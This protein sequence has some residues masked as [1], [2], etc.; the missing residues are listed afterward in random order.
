[1]TFDEPYNNLVSIDRTFDSIKKMKALA[2]DRVQLY[3]DPETGE[4]L[5]IHDDDFIQTLKFQNPS[6]PFL[7]NDNRWIFTLNPIISLYLQNK[8]QYS[9]YWFV[10][11]YLQ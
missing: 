6:A 3:G 7:K 1:L 10:L 11:Y 5:E 4:M 9:R 8:K 2:G